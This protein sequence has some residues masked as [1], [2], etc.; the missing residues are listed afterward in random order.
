M[1]RVSYCKIAWT[2]WGSRRLGEHE[3]S[4]DVRGRNKRKVG[5]ALGTGCGY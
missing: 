1:G 3:S 5:G 4:E 2:I